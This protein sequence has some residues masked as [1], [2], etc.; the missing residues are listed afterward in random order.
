MEDVPQEPHNTLTH[1]VFMA[2]YE[3]NGNLFAN[4]T[5][6]GKFAWNSVEFHDYSNSG[7]FELRNCCRNFIFLIVKCVPAN[8]EHVLPSLESSPA[9]DSSDFMNQ[10]TFLLYL[11]VASGIKFQDSMHQLFLHA[12]LPSH[13]SSYLPNTHTFMKTY[14]T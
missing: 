7:P 3:L 6:V 13:C 11:S 9:I 2:I 5:L 12:P 14:V 8:L 4:Q 10:K 1:F